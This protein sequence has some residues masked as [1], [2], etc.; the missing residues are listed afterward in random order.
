[1]T[2]PAEALKEESPLEEPLVKEELLLKEEPQVKEELL[3]K[4]GPLVIVALHTALLRSEII[5]L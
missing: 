1:M 3:V 5:I 4:E 2:S